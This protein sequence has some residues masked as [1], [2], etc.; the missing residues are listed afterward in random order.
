MKIPILAVVLATAASL[1][2]EAV[3]SSE[4]EVTIRVMEMNEYQ[5]ESVMK[6]IELPDI[7]NEGAH[8]QTQL[9]APEHNREQKVEQ[10]GSMS[11]GQT[12]GDDDENR[13]IEW[14]QEREEIMD[15]E[16][17]NHER[18]ATEPVGGPRGN[19]PQG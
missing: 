4:D 19:G 3:A 17:E 9:K 16:F 13:D 1:P 6:V 14:D 15:R 12:Q 7:S 11:M 2:F 8:E 10:T 5:K 18:N